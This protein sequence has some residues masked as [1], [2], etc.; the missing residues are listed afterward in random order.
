MNISLATG[1]LQRL[2]SGSRRAGRLFWHWWTSELKEALPPRIQK[3]IR[4]ADRTLRVTL[5]GQSIDI[6][7][8]GADG[9]LPLGELDL[10]DPAAGDRDAV[11]QALQ[12]LTPAPGA[13]A[14]ELAA[15]HVFKRVLE[16]PASTE[17]R[18]VDVLQ[19]EM[20]RFTPFTGKQVYFAHRVIGRD[21]DNKQIT[22]Q[23]V[24]ARR[25]LVDRLLEVLG[26]CDLEV[27][28]VTVPA[29][30]AGIGDWNLLPRQMR[31]G[32][33]L[34]KRLLPLSLGAACVALLIAAMALPLIAQK[35]TMRA[36]ESEIAE[37]RPVAQAVAQTRDE[38]A[39]LVGEQGFFA[40]KRA[41]LPTTIQL[42]DEIARIIPDDTWL[43]RLEVRGSKLRIQGESDG[44]S[45]LLALLEASDLIENAT[46][47]S[48][49][50]KNPRTS[51]DRFALEASIRQPEGRNSD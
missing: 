49:V 50:T 3:Y 13:V 45:S 36:I 21:S 22:V 20:D 24:I 34:R 16:L 11:K 6:K 29:G 18:L 15:E 40:A 19:F 32:T 5:R 28:A 26:S 4:D 14:I 17:E 12:A 41:E 48:P 43:V 2:T 46:F 10:H 7:V 44:A 30:A 51:N 38:I 31:A 23:L 1:D 25:S 42:M 9:V 8:R 39:A 47:S 33:G 37:L 35:N 27:S